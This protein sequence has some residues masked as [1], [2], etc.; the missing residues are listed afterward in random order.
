MRRCQIS[1]FRNLS[2]QVMSE[3]EEVK[4]NIDKASKELIKSK[5]KS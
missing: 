5:K 3:F 1:N 2:M 4:E